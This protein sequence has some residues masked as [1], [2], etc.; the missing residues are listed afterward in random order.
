MPYL[1]RL[2]ADTSA[3]AIQE[4]LACI[5]RRDLALI[6]P[7]GT[8]T[9]LT[10]DVDADALHTLHLYCETLGKDVVIIGGDEDLRAAAVAAGF[11]SATSLDAWKGASGSRFPR[12]AAS[13]SVDEGDVWP[14]SLSL[15]SVEPD[16][17]ADFDEL[18]E[19]VQQLLGGDDG[20]IG[21]RDRDAALE[22]RIARTTHP[23]DD[24]DGD[25]A[26]FAS[27]SY[28]DGITS[29]IRGTSGIEKCPD[30]L[31]ASSDEEK[32]SRSRMR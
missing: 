1:L 17:E 14:A 3:T 31:G 13:R 12:P 11:A 8:P 29:T 32:S 19:Y 5:R 4:A 23:L 26:I 9:A 16:Q 30:V 28:E 24:A 25:I 20:Y 10:G 21:P 15:V 2:H 27:E 6:F 22:A 18:P 7:Y